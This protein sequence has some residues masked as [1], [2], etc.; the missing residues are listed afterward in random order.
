MGSEGT[1]RPGVLPI[2]EKKLSITIE[3]ERRVT[4]LS[5]GGCD[6]AFESRGPS[7]RASKRK[8]LRNQIK[9][10]RKAAGRK[11]KNLMNFVRSK[12]GK[13][14]GSDTVT[15]SETVTIVS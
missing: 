12:F 3:D 13:T 5:F 7:R 2:P 11:K 6:H 10:L 15:R 4:V 1:L 14:K 8:S 9:A